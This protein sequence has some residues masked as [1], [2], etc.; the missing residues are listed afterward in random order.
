MT[1]L[2][3]I[4]RIRHHRELSTD[5]KRKWKAKWNGIK[6]H[7]HKLYVETMKL[8]ELN[9]SGHLCM[10]LLSRRSSLYR[11][12]CESIVFALS[13]KIAENVLF[14]FPNLHPLRMPWITILAKAT[15]SLAGA[16]F[17]YH[18]NQNKLTC[19]LNSNYKHHHK[20]LFST[21]QRRTQFWRWCW[22]WC[23]C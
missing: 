5:R 10:S 15:F 11:A 9:V 8:F 3:K 14:F 17:N 18:V 20:I 1:H 22:C 12:K 7:T 2:N 4:S 21:K 6:K 13:R 23:W 19:N 16:H